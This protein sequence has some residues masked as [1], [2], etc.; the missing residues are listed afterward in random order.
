MKRSVIFCVLF[1]L[2]FFFCRSE[3]ENMKARITYY[4]HS[5]F[6][7]QY[8]GKRILVDP[9]TPEWFDY[10]LPKGKLDY[11]FASHV[12]K[13]HSHFD[14]LDVENKYFASGET[15]QFECQNQG[16]ASRLKGKV[17]ERIGDH[18]F[19]FW[20]VPSFH[21]DVKGARNGV[22][23]ILCFDFAGVKISATGSKRS[24]SW[25]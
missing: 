25:R 17:T 7:F 15:D 19:T 11:G 23:G 1:F 2:S 3:R 12:A 8:A 10:G 14:G 9:F 24:R 22:N 21:D 18:Q 5:C 20:T 16:K 13:D 4:G 6:E